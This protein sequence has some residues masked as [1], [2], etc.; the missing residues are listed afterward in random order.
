MNPLPLLG[1]GR[2]RIHFILSASEPLILRPLAPGPWPWPRCSGLMERSW[3]WESSWNR[4][5]GDLR[6]GLAI[7]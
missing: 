5:M 2:P 7:N 1:A 6:E 4:A 3:Y